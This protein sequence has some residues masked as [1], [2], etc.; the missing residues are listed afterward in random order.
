MSESATENCA[1]FLSMQFIFVPVASSFFR[2]ESFTR[3]VM[4]LGGSKGACLG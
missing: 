4:S 1:K 3:Y 2:L